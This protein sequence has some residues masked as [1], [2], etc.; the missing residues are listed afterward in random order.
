[1]TLKDG[2]TKE[3]TQFISYPATKALAKLAAHPVDL[4]KSDVL[5]PERLASY[6]GQ[7]CGY[8]LLYGTELVDDA[9]MEALKQ[10]AKESDA[11]AKMT[12]MQDGEV[13]NK[14]ENYPSEDRPALHTATRDF[15]DHPRLAKRAKE[16]AIEAKLEVEKLRSFIAKLDSTGQFDEIISIGIGG[17]DLGPR[18]NYFALESFL[19][20]GRK[21]HFISNVDPDDAAAVLK[22]VTD[23]KRTLVIVISKSGTTLETAVNEEFVARQFKEAGLDRRDH[24]IAITQRGTPMDNRDNYLESFYIWDWIGGRYSSTSLVGGLLL[25]FAFGFDVYFEFLKGAHAMDEAALEKD[26][27]KNLPLLAALLSIWNHN[28][29]GYATIALIPYSQPLFRYPAH[30]QQVSMESNGKYIDKHGNFVNF[31]T[32]PVIWGEPGTNAQHSFFQLLHQGTAPIPVCMIAFK[33]SQQGV[34]LNVQGTTS[35]EKLLSNMFAQSLAL[36]TG[37]KSENPNK[38]FP[39]NRPSSILLGEQLTPFALGALLSF[40]ENKVAFE[41]FIWGINSFDQEGVELGKGL[42]KK[43]I[44]C[45]AAKH[46]EEDKSSYPLGDAYLKHLDDLR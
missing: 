31:Q 34:D 23:L 15:F 19:K 12:R 27:K 24:F 35:Q 18:A 26:L 14:I 10:L 2:Q 25:S 3:K 5:T 8:K 11:L 36:A 28:F 32:G 17:S 4:T 1:M 46:R 13:V 41:G 16:A 33:N 40:F 7:A 38:F 39:G 30:I 6:Y 29:L 22:S 21:V 42:A 44:S 43:I 37:Q 45:F 20:P 9:V